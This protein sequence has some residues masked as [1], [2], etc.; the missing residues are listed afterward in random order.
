MPTVQSRRIL[1]PRLL[2]TAV[3]LTM[4]IALTIAFPSPV[5]GDPGPAAQSS[6]DALAQTYY[7]LLLRN[8][9]YVESLWVPDNNAYSSVEAMVGNA[10]LLRFGRYDA[11]AGKSVV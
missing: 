8:T 7:G 2:T 5:R 6:E 3:A 9:P 4:M 11:A 10:V 1:H